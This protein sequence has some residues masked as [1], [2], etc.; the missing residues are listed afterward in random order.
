MDGVCI[1][2]D[3]CNVLDGTI[4]IYIDRSISIC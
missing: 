3:R 2:L 1:S 4:R